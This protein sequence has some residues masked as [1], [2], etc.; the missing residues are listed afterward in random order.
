MKEYIQN[1]NGEVA[2]V[3][4]DAPLPPK[5]FRFTKKFIRTLFLTVPVLLLLSFAG[6]FFWGFGHRLQT[7][8]TPN[9]PTVISESDKRIQELEEDLRLSRE[10]NTKM[11]E[12]L[13]SQ[14]TETKGV[15]KPFLMSIKEPY[16][17]QDLTAAKKVAVNQFEFVADKEKA[18]LKFLITNNDQE[19]KISGHVIVYML[20]DAGILGYPRGANLT[21]L[22]GTKFS[23]GEPFSVSRLRPTNAEFAK[24]PAGETVKFV[25]YIFTREG[26]LLLIHETSPFK[27]GAKS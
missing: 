3:I 11:S 1:T 18:S 27:V 21:T 26:D 24:A 19:T 22:Q 23:V 8:P 13:A 2:I 16:G 14:K 9:F 20:S 10:S 5:Y 4:Y 15:E 17:M 25:I 12:K 6:L 7:T